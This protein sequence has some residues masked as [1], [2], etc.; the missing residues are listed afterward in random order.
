MLHQSVLAAQWHC[1]LLESGLPNPHR[2]SLN[3]RPKATSLPLPFPMLLLCPLSGNACRSV[4]PGTKKMLRAIANRRWHI[5][6]VTVPQRVG[7][8]EKGRECHRSTGTARKRR[9][10][11]VRMA[12]CLRALLCKPPALRKARACLSKARFRP[13]RDLQAFSPFIAVIS[14]PGPLDVS[15]K[16]ALHISRSAWRHYAQAGQWLNGSEQ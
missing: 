5:A 13:S 16:A 9:D 11:C 8:R 7:E 6:K 10:A 12:E 1:D 4:N 2:A 15:R 14:V 3:R